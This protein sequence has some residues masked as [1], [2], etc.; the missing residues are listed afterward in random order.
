MPDEMLSIDS[1]RALIDPAASEPAALFFVESSRHTCITSL[2]KFNREFSY[3]KGNFTA[4]CAS[5]KL[6]IELSRRN[7]FLQWPS[8]LPAIL[9]RFFIV[10]IRK[11]AQKMGKYA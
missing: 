8:R 10:V 6:R 2:N 7:D 5:E 1:L 4:I 9:S 11:Y 3:A